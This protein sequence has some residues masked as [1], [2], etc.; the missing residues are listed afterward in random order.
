MLALGGSFY[1]PNLEWVNA[2]VEE[3]KVE[4]A[5][6]F[7]VTKLWDPFENP[8]FAA[9]DAVYEAQRSLLL[10]LFVAL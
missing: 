7:V 10:L 9:S 6:H 3:N 4:I 1:L 5:K 8:L 2:K